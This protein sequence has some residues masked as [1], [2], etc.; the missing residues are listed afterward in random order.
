[1]YLFEYAT[2]RLVPRI[3]RE[4]FVNTGVI[5]YCR[6]QQFL[7]CRWQLPETRLLAL[8]GSTASTNLPLVEL[9]ARLRAIEHI[10]AG[11][12]GAG[13]IGQ[14]GTAERFRWLTAQRSTT[15]QASLVH[16]GLCTDPHLMLE[17]LFSQL[18]Q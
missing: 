17:K 10:C 14:F 13:P 11:G 4:E 3:E 7:Q 12:Q 6:D 8:A 18:V 9:R 15:L 5:L 1:M 16:P 2:L